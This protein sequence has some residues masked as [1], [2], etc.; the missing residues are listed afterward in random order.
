MLG[1]EFSDTD[2][3]V[4]ATST[5]FALTSSMAAA[6]LS[7]RERSPVLGAAGVAAAAA[8]FV[9]V[10][11]GMWG[12]LDSEVFWRIT[13]II[14][15]VALESAHVAFIWSRLRPTD[16]TSVAR[17]TRAAIGLAV[18]SAVLGI[19][20]IAGLEGNETLYVELLGVV[21]VGQLLCTVLAPL[22]RRLSAGAERPVIAVATERERL[23]TEL[24][25]V[26][27]RLE[28]L[29]A[30]PRVNAECERLRR[31]ARTVGVQ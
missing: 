14:A 26:A 3:K 5:L 18:V 17:I 15:I 1:G 2:W 27:D 22:V 13:G 9:L 24:T 23:A 20:P 16:P 30:G 25:A 19:A 6:G 4:I 31:L 11:F 21:L 10:S 12:E 28:R 7:V 29:E 8:A